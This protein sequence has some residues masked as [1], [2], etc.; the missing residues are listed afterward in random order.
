MKNF[1]VKSIIGGLIILI[2]GMFSIST[3]ASDHSSQVVNPITYSVSTQKMNF[4]KSEVS[5]TSYGWKIA[6]AIEIIAP[7][8]QEAMQKLWEN[9]GIPSSE[10]KNYTLVNIKETR[11][12]AWGAIIVGQNYLTITADI[13][14]D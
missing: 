4:Y 9:S 6:V 13:V 11:G 14:K 1:K 10:Q 7:S 2:V 3:F 12:T 5:G 8:Y